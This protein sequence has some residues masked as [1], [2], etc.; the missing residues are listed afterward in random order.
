M[1]RKNDTFSQIIVGFFMLTLMV[2][3]G[4][5]TIA[6]SGVDIL[7]NRNRK[8]IRVAFDEVGGLREHDDVIYRGTKVGVV[9]HVIITPQKLY[10]EA[11]IDENVILRDGY[12]AS[13]CKL[14]M[15]GGNYLLLEEGNG[16]EID[17][18]TIVLKGDRPTDWMREISTIIDNLERITASPELR[19]VATN[20]VVM[21]DH[22]K[23]FTEKADALVTRLEKGEGTLGKL[24]TND[25]SIYTDLK[26]TMANTRQISEKLN[27]EKL[28]NDLSVSIAGLRKAVDQ[29]NSNRTID[30]ADALVANLNA[31]VASLQSGKGTLGKLIEDPTMYD[32]VNGLI[33]DARQVLDNFR[34]TTPI[35][36]FSSLAI[37]GF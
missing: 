6:I 10:V 2:L 14:S 33:T 27:N 35:S 34:D 37:G 17:P 12:R 36:T 31:V 29:F 28:Y 25:D 19:K 15:L 3:L 8:E 20:L 22:A 16:G 9:E 21:S 26:E 24:M 5:F 30:K 11:K 13:V 32:K 23:S 4:Y 7:T 1:K 18:S